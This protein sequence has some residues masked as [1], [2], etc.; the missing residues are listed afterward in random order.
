[1]TRSR[2]QQ[3]AVVGGGVLGVST[4]AQLARAGVDVV[5]VTES[6]LVSQASGRSLSWLNSA[7]LRS[8]YYHRLRMAGIDRY[9]TLFAQ[10]PGSG[11]LRFDGGLSW[12]AEDQADDLV[13]QHE[14]ELALGYDSHRLTAD[15]VAD[16]VPGVDPDA[17]PTAGALWRP[18]E[19]WV[20]LPSL[21]RFLAADLLQ[22]GGRVVTDAGPVRVVTEGEAVAGVRGDRGEWFPADSVVLAAGAAV[23]ALLAELGVTIPDA[24]PTALLVATE[25]V[26]HEL[27][28]VLNTPRV[29]LRPRPD[30]GLS[31]DADWASSS[32]SRAADGRYEVAEGVVEKLLGEASRVLAGHAELREAWCGIGPK[33]IPGDGEPVL[34][35]IDAVPGL[36]VTFT[37]SGATL[38]LIAGELV[39][40]EIVHGAAHPM[41]ADF[42]ARRFG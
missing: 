34:G 1:M 13:R 6:G 9:R 31:V 21:V 32:V 40:H 14:H 37:H 4:A 30:G 5:L 10:N 35:R 16:H 2:A 36:Y 26:P 28:A 15:Q 39:A 3:V 29:S 33:P 17:V 23:P 42:N 41:L 27:T 20:D 22:H 11:W 18:G 38:G 8:E 24:S 12:L 19:G 7:G 25:P